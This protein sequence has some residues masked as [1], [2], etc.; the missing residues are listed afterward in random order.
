[1]CVWGP[2][3][4]LK[5]LAELTAFIDKLATTPLNKLGIIFV[6]M[7]VLQTADNHIGV[8]AYT[9]I[10]PASGL[11]ARSLDFLNSF[12]HIANLA[13]EEKVDVLLIVGDF[14]NRVN[15]H[16][17]YILEVIRKLKQVSKSGITTIIVSGN[18]ETP[19]MAT[20]LNPLVL[21]GEIDGVHVALEPTTI[22]V[23]GY[24]FV[25]VPSPPNFDEIRNLFEPLLVVALQKSKSD[26]KILASHIPIGQALTS[27]EVMLESFIGECVDISQIPPKF[28]YVALGHIHKFQLI[29]HEKMPIYYSG[30]SERV[31][32]N[33]EHDD[34]YALLVELQDKA[35]VSPIKLP[36]RRMMTLLDKDCSGLSATKITQ[37][38]LNSIE[39]NKGTL[40]DTIVRIKLEN[41][42][43]DESRLIDWDKIKGQ[44]NEEQVFDY[45]MQPR[46][47]VTLP[48]SSK[49][50]GEY[51]L[52]PS[53]ELELYVKGK[54]E[55]R[56]KMKLLLRLG[57]E[58]INEAKEMTPIET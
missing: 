17:R 3:I 31:E 27:S 30:S 1:M 57:N 28:A 14:L 26:K 53:K 33:E 40:A 46:T 55:Y 9:R 39:E 18:H 25:C 43:V 34:K 2:Y 52:P 19:R 35:K 32:F 44:L 20:T 6:S 54:K 11:N 13:I 41:I 10:D 21:L 48:E 24:D 47:T 45:K 42:D 8:T 16:P 58:I 12:L 22:E 4:P 36:V 15:I 38:V 50:A 49:L 51:I 5:I 23:N 7:R 56:G 29:P 37:L